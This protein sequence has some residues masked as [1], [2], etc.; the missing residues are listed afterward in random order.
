[1]ISLGLG[2]SSA[3]PAGERSAPPPVAG[4]AGAGSASGFGDFFQHLLGRRSR[5]IA[6][7]GGEPTQPGPA[8]G[9]GWPQGD[10]D[11][12]DHALG[13]ITESDAPVFAPGLA[14][15]GL[16]VEAPARL[17]T[18]APGLPEMS[19][20]D[21]GSD[22]SDGGLLALAVDRPPRG[23]AGMP[24]WSP[25]V[26]GR[27]PEERADGPVR[28]GR[29]RVAGGAKSQD[30]QAANALPT[31]VFPEAI[32]P[33]TPTWMAAPAGPEFQRRSEE[34]NLQL[35]QAPPRHPRAERVLADLFARTPV[36]PPGAAVDPPHE[37]PG[38]GSAAVPATWLGPIDATAQRAPL[39][40]TE[41]LAGEPVETGEPTPGR[42]PAARPVVPFDRPRVA[43]PPAALPGDNAPPTD[44]DVPPTALDSADSG[45]ASA[46][47]AERPA[48]APA[49]P[50]LDLV[51]D[52]RVRD[53]QTAVAAFDPRRA[54]VA[55]A[56]L[57][58]DTARFARPQDAGP[59]WTESSEPPA[60]GSS[61]GAPQAAPRAAE[62]S[63]TAFP[64]L[65]LMA[66]SPQLAAES[67]RAESPGLAP[68]AAPPSDAEL[69]DQIVQSLRLQAIQGGGEAR[70][71]L[72]PEYLGEL[73]VRVQVQNGVVTARLEAEVP[74]VREWIER[75][76]V[77][78]RQ[79]LGE[80]GLTL[81]ALIISDKAE[82]E[83]SFARDPHQEQD[84]RDP[85]KPSPR[86]RRR[87][88]DGDAPRFEVV[89]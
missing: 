56:T 75:H 78:L 53:R 88:A 42:E 55:P 17:P 5:D 33:A 18:P 30:T 36:A 40:R 70:V 51:R 31:E 15:F 41:P 14:D 72:R 12:V 68:P 79:A 61:E 27:M 39:S 34:S 21:R 82:G 19:G 7:N 85:D 77:S 29:A 76:E 65:T 10:I 9:R 74:A 47:S 87:Q 80:H 26:T 62:S 16:W 8:R 48:K 89:V 73:T 6:S 69:P 24:G 43:A 71:H 2:P 46:E 4:A 58:D 54:R 32:R 84:P 52:A 22:V 3:A 81:E 67:V 86:G 11:E 44:A 63:G 57:R 1:V 59:S 50:M 37:V 49:E 35:A 28:A 38:R 64:H 25:S 66:S 60:H 83:E 20:P 13:E 45:T 23:S